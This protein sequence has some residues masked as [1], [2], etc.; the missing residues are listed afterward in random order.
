MTAIFIVNAIGMALIAMAIVSL[1]IWAI[2]TQNDIS[3]RPT[4]LR[5]ARIRPGLAGSLR[6][7][8]PVGLLD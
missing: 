5:R 3:L 6:Q 2:V 1:L 4:W 8:R 7:R